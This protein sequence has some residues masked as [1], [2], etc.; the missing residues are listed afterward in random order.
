MTIEERAAHL[1][2]RVHY[3][4][5]PEAETDILVALQAVDA[6]A[7]VDGRR[8]IISEA[9]Q[10]QLGFLVEIGQIEEGDRQAVLNRAEQYATL[11]SARVVGLYHILDATRSLEQE[12]DAEKHERHVA[13][14]D[15]R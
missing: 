15:S 2:E 13:C 12:A 8:M 1:A 10:R 6:E 14:E 11:K 5:W 4:N 7:R 3:A 9:A